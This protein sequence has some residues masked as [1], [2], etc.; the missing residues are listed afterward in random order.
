MHCETD[1]KA[2]LNF[3]NWYLHE[4][5]DE[6]RGTKLVLLSCENWFQLSGYG[7]CQTHVP[8]LQKIRSSATEVHYM[9]LQSVCC[10]L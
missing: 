4:V 8:G 9:M 6:E 7:P 5:H 3:V 2:R 1:R 10:V